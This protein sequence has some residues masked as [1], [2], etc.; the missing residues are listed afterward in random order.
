MQSAKQFT[1]ILRALDNDLSNKVWVYDAAGS[2]IIKHWG[3]KTCGGKMYCKKVRFGM[4]TGCRLLFFIGWPSQESE[5]YL[6]VSL[7]EDRHQ[8][9][10]SESRDVSNML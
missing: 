9:G 8:R 2:I 5:F 6:T 1:Q 7:H 4:S 3:M 10:Q